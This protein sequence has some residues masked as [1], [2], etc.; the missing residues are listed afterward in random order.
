MPE[1]AF[2]MYVITAIQY[3]MY[4]YTKKCSKK[5]KKNKKKQVRVPDSV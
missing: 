1:R 5:T 3:N 2:T 4:K